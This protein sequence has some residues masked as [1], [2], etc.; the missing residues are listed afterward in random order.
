M[1]SLVSYTLGFTINT[2]VG[3]MN[4]NVPLLGMFWAGD[5]HINMHRANDDLLFK[6]FRLKGTNES[7]WYSEGRLSAE[8]TDKIWSY[9]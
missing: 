5:Y 8:R 7:E 2:T 4:I 3:Y 6:F 9:K 1:K